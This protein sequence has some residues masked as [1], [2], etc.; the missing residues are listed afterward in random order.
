[1][2]HPILFSGPLYFM[3]IIHKIVVKVRVK[4]RNGKI[5]N[6]VFL[7]FLHVFNFNIL[8]KV[9]VECKFT[10]DYRDKSGYIHS[11]VSTGFD[12]PP[13]YVRV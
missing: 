9:M 13:H 11:L 10:T 3:F 5:L 12:L 7:G 2:T 4:S 1:M 6:R 8:N